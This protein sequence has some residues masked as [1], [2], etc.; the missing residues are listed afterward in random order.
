[1]IQEPNTKINVIYCLVKYK[2]SV[3]EAL[4]DSASTRNIISKDF[5]MK[6]NLRTRE[7]KELTLIV[8]NTDIMKLNQTVTIRLQPINSEK[9]I[10][11][12]FYVAEKTPNDIV[13]GNEFHTTHDSVI[14]Y[15]RWK[16]HINEVSMDIYKT[17]IGNNDSI[18]EIDKIFFEK[19]SITRESEFEN[20]FLDE[21]FKNYKDTIVPHEGINMNP[22]KI[23]LT[24]EIVTTRYKNYPVPH[25]FIEPAKE[26]INRLINEHVIEKTDSKI[27]SPAFLI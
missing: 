25:K 3:L 5:V 21:L 15:K 26:E 8:E 10:K 22:V 16:L 1:M 9:E 23:K 19:F 14:D 17:E 4:I 18:N 6:N 2:D 7:D 27:I 11:V 12:R 20:E 13:L 24:K